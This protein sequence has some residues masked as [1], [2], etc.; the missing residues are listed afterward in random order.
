[1]HWKR[2]SLVRCPSRVWI[3]R[4]QDHVLVCKVDQQGIL[5]T[6]SKDTSPH[7]TSIYYLTEYA[8]RLIKYP[9]PNSLQK[10]ALAENMVNCRVDNLKVDTR[11]QRC[12]YTR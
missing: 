3:A 7:V 10:H 1:V 11:T 9:A 12:I 2:I 4:P 5:G 6:P 8:E